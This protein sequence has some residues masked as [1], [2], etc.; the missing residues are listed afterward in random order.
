MQTVQDGDIFTVSTSEALQSNCW[1]GQKMTTPVKLR[2]IMGENNSEK[3]TLPSGIPESVED[4]KLEI[5]R[6]C[7]VAEDF[8]LQYMD[9]DFDE[10]INLTSTAALQHLGTVKV[11]TNAQEATGEGSTPQVLRSLSVESTSLSSTDTEILSTPDSSPSPTSMLRSQAW[12][13]SF[14]IPQFS[15]EVELQLVKANQ[16]YHKNGT[17]LNPSPKL[18]SAILESLASVII[19]YKAYPTSAEFDDVAEALIKTHACLKEQGSVTGF[20]GWK[21]S[22]KYKMANYRSSLRNIT[23]ELSI[24]SMKRRGGHTSPNQVKKPRKAEVNFLPDYP[25]G[26]NQETLENERLELLSEVKKRDN[27]QIIKVKMD[28]TFAYR[29]KEVVVDMPSIAEFQSR[30]PALFAESEISAEFTRITTIPLMSK[31]MS[32]LDHHSA[33]LSRVCLK[34]G[35]VARRKIAEI[36]ASINENDTIATRRACNLKSL[37]VYLNEDP[38]KL[39]KEY[40]D[41]NFDN[42]QSE[43][44]MTALGIYVIKHEGAD[45]SDPPE[46]VTR[47]LKSLNNDGNGNNKQL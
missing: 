45:A 46:D 24:N 17:L 4:L 41:V 33:K 23:S 21:I 38:E 12:P 20:Y 7:A 1:V 2:I 15:Y 22:L 25:V 36:M 10:F 37:A 16:E 9:V 11:I 19:K 32:E 3:L 39:I 18:K 40:L 35:G 44:D 29:R 47:V 34:K 13:A 28:K 5:K 27:N 14:P 6:Q 26:E 42:A 31:F 8:R 43:L 30:W